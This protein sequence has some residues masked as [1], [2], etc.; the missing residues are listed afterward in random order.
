M[1]CVK[2]KGPESSVSAKITNERGMPIIKKYLK[3]EIKNRGLFAKTK[4]VGKIIKIPN[5]VDTRLTQSSY[6]IAM[7]TPWIKINV[8]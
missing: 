4:Y 2:P 6:V 1:T 8:E 7:T 5:W 3:N